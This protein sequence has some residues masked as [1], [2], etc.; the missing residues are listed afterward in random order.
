M[1]P[2]RRRPDMNRG[3]PYLRLAA[4]AVAVF[5]VASFA[6]DPPGQGPAGK[7]VAIFSGDNA[8]EGHGPK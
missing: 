6:G 2:L 3:V 8:A 4:L 7:P 1:M 5:V